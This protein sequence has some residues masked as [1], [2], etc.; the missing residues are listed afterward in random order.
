MKN[1]TEKLSL[2][3]MKV[4][5]YGTMLQYEK[6][7]ISREELDGAHIGFLMLIAY[8]FSPAV[9]DEFFEERQKENARS[10]EGSDKPSLKVVQ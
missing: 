8:V 6:G 4:A 9:S 5:W 2:E 7:T 1:R 10:Q 3:D